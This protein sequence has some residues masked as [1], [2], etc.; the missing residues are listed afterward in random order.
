MFVF[1]CYALCTRSTFLLS[2]RQGNNLTNY[3]IKHGIHD[4]VPAE[5][6]WRNK[7]AVTPV[8]DQGTLGS[9]W[10]FSATAQIEGQ[11]YLKYGQLKNLSVEQFLECDSF[12]GKEK[13]F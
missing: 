2:P 11:L 9:C 5:L 1:I 12:H 8:K 10:A 7:G 13:C 3:T 6:D 4:N